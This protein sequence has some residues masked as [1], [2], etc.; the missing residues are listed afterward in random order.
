[1]LFVLQDVQF[2]SPVVLIHVSAHQVDYTA[3]AE[4][5]KA[6]V[7]SNEPGLGTENPADVQMNVQEPPGGLQGEGGGGGGYG[8]GGGGG[9]YGGG[10]GGY[11]PPPK[12]KPSYGGSKGGGYGG[13]GGGGGYAAA[14]AAATNQLS[15]AKSVNHNQGGR[16]MSYYR[17]A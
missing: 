4:G 5:F 15:V 14:A 11:S 1:M 10:G 17:R 6:V 16:S 3:G 9:G 8:G 12:P 13:G 7:S 2:R